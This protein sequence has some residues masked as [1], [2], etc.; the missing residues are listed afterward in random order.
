MKKARISLVLD[1]ETREL[2]EQHAKTTNRS[3][4]ASVEWLIKKY[5]EHDLSVSNSMPAVI[6]RG[7]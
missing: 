6:K 5:C 1:E 2:V 3:L 4:S 7:E